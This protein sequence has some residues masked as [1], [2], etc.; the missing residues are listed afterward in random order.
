MCLFPEKKK[1]RKKERKKGKK[2]RKNP[3]L[4][5]RTLTGLSVDQFSIFLGICVCH[6]R[7]SILVIFQENY[8]GGGKERICAKFQWRV[9]STDDTLQDGGRFFLRWSRSVQ[10]KCFFEQQVRTVWHY[11]Q[12]K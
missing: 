4:L 7:V 3:G 12:F 1:K 5:S 10:G 11:A 9:C 2:Q 6:L 8:Y